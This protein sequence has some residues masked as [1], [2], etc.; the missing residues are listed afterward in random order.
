MEQVASLSPGTQAF[1]LCKDLLMR[2]L[3]TGRT[4][5][6]RVLAEK[7]KLELE[8]CAHQRASYKISFSG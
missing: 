3:L 1:T 8:M 5:R 7:L 4:R 6:M 2:M